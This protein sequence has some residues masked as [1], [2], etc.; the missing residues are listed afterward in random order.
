MTMPSPPPVF[1]PLSDSSAS[2]K[3]P[4]KAASTP[5]CARAVAPSPSAR[6]V[7]SAYS[8]S[9]TAGAAH[10]RPSAIVRGGPSLCK[11]S[12]QSRVV[13]RRSARRVVFF[14]CVPCARIC[15]KVNLRYASHALHRAA[16]IALRTQLPLTCAPRLHVFRFTFEA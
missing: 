15:R 12:A 6:S 7:T 2:R 14:Q 9:A 5:R 4:E 11:V 13:G 8:S 3:T 10:A 16:S 1:A